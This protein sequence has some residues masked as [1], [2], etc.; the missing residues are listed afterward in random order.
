MRTTS[1]PSSRERAPI[2]QGHRQRRAIMCSEAVWWRCHR[3]IVSGYLIARGETVPR[4]MGQDRV[5]PARLTAGA[6]IR[7]GGSVVYP[8]VEG[9]AAAQAP[10]TQPEP[11]ER[12]GA[13]RTPGERWRDNDMAA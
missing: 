4:I 3:R 5:G 11:D 7:T 10:A 1:L 8:D 12:R 2:A 13:G 6:V 9:D